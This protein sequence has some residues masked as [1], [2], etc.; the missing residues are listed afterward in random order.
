[1]RSSQVLSS[2]PTHKPS[3]SP[4]PW[5]KEDHAPYSLL[6]HLFGGM[7]Q[8]MTRSSRNDLRIPQPLL[9]RGASEHLTFLPKGQGTFA[10][11]AKQP[12]QCFVQFCEG[13][14]TFILMR[15]SGYERPGSHRG[16]QERLLHPRAFYPINA[17]SQGQI[18]SGGP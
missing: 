11:L 5:K 13:R 1:M 8:A 3:V 10:H 16:L 12:S 4:L 15:D 7:I 17:A 9:S 14:T 2:F 6:H 18:T